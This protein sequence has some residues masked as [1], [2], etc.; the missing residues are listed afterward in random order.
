MLSQ[1]VFSMRQLAIA[2]VDEHTLQIQLKSP[3]AP[4][5][6]LIASTENAIVSQAAVKRYGEDFG[7]NP[8]GTGPFK[9]IQW[10]R[11]D[12]IELQAYDEHWAGKPAINKLIF[13]SIPDNSIRF[14]ELQADTFMLWNFLI[15]KI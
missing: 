5:L 7:N 6:S 12:Q 14:M 4:F 13:R 15:L 11:N 10:D 1:V 3:Y 9:F 2:A 8:V